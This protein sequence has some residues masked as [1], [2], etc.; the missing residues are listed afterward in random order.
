[1]SEPRPLSIAKVLWPY[2][3]LWLLV[4][5]ALGATVVVQIATDRER[6]L[7]AARS[8]VDD[9]S[10]LL[11]DNVARTLDGIDRTLTVVKSV[12][13]RNLSSTPPEMLVEAS[14][15]DDDVEHR[16]AVFDRNGFLQTAIGTDAERALWNVSS[17]IDFVDAS[18]YPG[19]Q[20]RVQRPVRVAQGSEQA[21]VPI[22]K[23]LDDA[24]GE[25]DGVV[26]AAIDTKRLL[27]SSTEARE[28]NPVVLGIA[29]TGGQ[30][31]AHSGAVTPTRESRAREASTLPAIR[32]N[33]DTRIEWRAIDDRPTLVAVRSVGASGLAVFAGID[34]GAVFASNRFF[35]THSI[36]FLA[37]TLSAITLP[38]AFVARR[39]VRE[40]DRLQRR[41]TERANDRSRARSD[42]LTGIANRAAFDEHLKNCH[43][44]LARY[45]KPFVLAFVDVDDFKRINDEKGR[46]AGDGA[47]RRLARTM[48]DS[49]RETDLVAR[50][51]GDKFAILMPGTRVT[52]VKRVLDQLRSTLGVDA[53]IGG[54]S[55]TFS[56]GVVAFESAPPRPIDAVNL[57]DSLMHEVKGSGRDGIRYAIYRD[58]E[59]LSE[60]HAA[61]A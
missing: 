31:I 24:A 22:V 29:S 32:A 50:V 59:L 12:H 53:V 16:F 34:E 28:P 19:S 60:A 49:V 9:L 20:L 48:R 3:L 52:S 30:L 44:L 46:D 10:R 38:L 25:F 39:A 58:H 1:M 36:G 47:L 57:A 14:R 5:A 37:L 54:W 7:A 61:A 8:V 6:D 13:E 15:L 33:G 55:V 26:A 21:F 11:A 41:E 42:P 43:L 51:D 56:V 18:M 40:L 27:A 17:V 23:R 35:V 45:G 4:A 2:V